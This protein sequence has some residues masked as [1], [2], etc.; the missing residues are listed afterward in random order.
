VI[1]HVGRLALRELWISFR[2]IGLLGLG[3]APGL[4]T[5]LAP[6]IAPGLVGPDPLLLGWGFA[7]AAV[8]ASALAAATL[9]LERRRGTAAWLALRAVPRA[10]I[11]LGWLVALAAPL[12]VAGAA[13]GVMAWLTVASGAASPLSQVAFGALVAAGVAAL[14]EAIAIGLLLGGL[15][16]RPVLA[17]MA[18]G[19]TAALLLGP[20]LLVVGEPP[21]LPGSGTG[22]LTVATALGRPLSDGLVALGTTLAMSAVVLLAAA[23][24]LAVVDL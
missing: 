13:S 22:L 1:A 12:L 17:A 16:R 18:G 20:G 5:A 19:I 6:G 24:A 8:V 14:L 10:A 21:Y 9:A 15:V 23:A 2:L 3:L 11:L 4:A 7:V